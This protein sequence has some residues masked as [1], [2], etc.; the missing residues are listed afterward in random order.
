MILHPGDYYASDEDI[1]IST[2]LGSCVSVALFD[3]G[4]RQGAMN[5]FMLPES[6]NINPEIDLILQDRARYGLFA[7]EMI[8]NEL[9]KMGSSKRDLKAKLFGGSN[10][11]R[12]INSVV[13]VGKLNIEFAMK[14]LKNEKIPIISSDLGGFSGRKLHY[15]PKTGKILMKKM[16][17]LRKIRHIA[18]SEKEY[19]ETLI[20]RT[21]PGD[22]VLF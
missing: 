18:E 4:R 6:R 13:S 3:P 14:F 16:D 7:M 12:E 9:M 22:I 21:T 8:I 1:I 2:V 19:T 10:M 5:H 11:F 17:S 15:F 20:P